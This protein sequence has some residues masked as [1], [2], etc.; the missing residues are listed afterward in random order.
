MTDHK[1][2]CKAENKVFNRR[3]IILLRTWVGIYAFTKSKWRT[4]SLTNEAKTT[5]RR[6]GGGGRGGGADYQN[7]KAHTP[8]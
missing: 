1:G 3:C 7:K 6:D 2:Y 8:Q 5:E 4:K